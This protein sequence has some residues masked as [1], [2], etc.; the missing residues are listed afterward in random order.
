MTTDRLKTEFGFLK[1]HLIEILE[2]ITSSEVYSNQKSYD[3][4]FTVEQQKTLFSVVDTMPI[5]VRLLPTMIMRP[6]KSVSGLVG[7]GLQDKITSHGIPCELC[8][9]AKCRM[10]R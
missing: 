2:K 10:R 6:I 4:K 7:I 5:G 1:T 3:K 9:M 8:K